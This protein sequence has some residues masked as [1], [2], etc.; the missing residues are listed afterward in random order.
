[1]GKG[2]H[3]SAFKNRLTSYTQK[4]SQDI[5]ELGELTVKDIPT[6]I[7]YY[8]KKGLKKFLDALQASSNITT[9][10]DYGS[11]VALSKTKPTRL[12]AEKTTKAFNKIVD[13][14]L[15]KQY[16]LV[17]MDISDLTSL[18]EK[19]NIAQKG[20]IIISALSQTLPP[21]F[22]T[23]GIVYGIQTAI[24]RIFPDNSAIRRD[25]YQRFP[26]RN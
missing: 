4:L 6:R 7:L 26:Y 16:D 5:H 18:V 23:E 21:Q 3:G 12:F 14:T 17:G 19:H 8:S 24:R 25:R 13:R 2:I 22:C 20:T 11:N 10:K 15:G 1:M 9:F